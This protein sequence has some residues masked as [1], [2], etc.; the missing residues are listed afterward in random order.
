MTKIEM[1]WCCDVF[2][3]GIS[4]SMIY[5]YCMVGKI[6]VL[7]LC[8]CLV[9]I[10][11]EIRLLHIYIYICLHMTYW[12]DIY[13]ISRYIFTYDGVSVMEYMMDAY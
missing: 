12:Y 9:I 5:A 6:C 10:N 13:N 8:S 4:I 1:V 3:H 11:F 2:G 7:D